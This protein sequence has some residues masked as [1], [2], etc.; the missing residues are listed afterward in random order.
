METLGAAAGCW[1][2]PQGMVQVNN[3]HPEEGMNCLR[4]KVPKSGESGRNTWESLETTGG[5]PV[6]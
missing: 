2:M 4:L 3:V 5:C 1:E 6:S